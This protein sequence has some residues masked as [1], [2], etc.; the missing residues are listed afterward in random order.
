[1]VAAELG[2]DTSIFPENS[3]VPAAAA[4]EAT[5]N[6][7]SQNVPASIE[8]GGSRLMVNSEKHGQTMSASSVTLIV[9]AVPSVA[10]EFVV[11]EPS[12]VNVLPVPSMF[13]TANSLPSSS[14]KPV[15]IG[16]AIMPAASVLTLATVTTAGLALLM[17]VGVTLVGVA[18]PLLKQ[19]VSPLALVALAMV[20]PS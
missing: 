19:M 12:K 9:G 8:S 18:A 6:D 2:S 20:N 5:C 14:G 13:P 3:N 16:A 15:S 10:V 1:M 11:S 4:A 17:A 7:G